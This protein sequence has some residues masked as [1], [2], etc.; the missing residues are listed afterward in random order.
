MLVGLRRSLA[1][2]SLQLDSWSHSDDNVLATRGF[3]QFFTHFGKRRGRVKSIMRHTTRSRAAEKLA[4]ASLE[5]EAGGRVVKIEKIGRQSGASLCTLCLHAGNW[6]AGITAGHIFNKTDRNTAAPERAPWRDDEWGFAIFH[7]GVI[8]HSAEEGRQQIQIGGKWS[9]LR[10]LIVPLCQSCRQIEE[11]LD[12]V[13]QQKY[14][15]NVRDWGVPDQMSLNG[16]PPGATIPASATI[17]IEDR[18]SDARYLAEIKQDY[19]LG[20]A[21][22]LYGTA[23]IPQTIDWWRTLLTRAERRESVLRALRVDLRSRATVTVN[24]QDLFPGRILF[25]REVRGPK[26]EE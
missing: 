14:I 10:G 8:V 18:R 11:K 21:G 6:G 24:G 2:T 16:L 5:K 20:I 22:T 4:W 13:A 1:R 3:S 19:F 9:V 7:S 25:A 26:G 15:L 23:G 12:A 17:T